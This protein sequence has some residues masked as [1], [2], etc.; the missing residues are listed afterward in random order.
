MGNMKVLKEILLIKLWGKLLLNQ[1]DC[2]GIGTALY[3]STVLEV[4]QI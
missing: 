2:T 1:T 4:Q 3:S